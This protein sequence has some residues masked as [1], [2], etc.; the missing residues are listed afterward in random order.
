M[1]LR[2]RRGRQAGYAGKHSRP[3]RGW[4][5]LFACQARIVSFIESPCSS[6]P[7]LWHQV[8]SLLDCRSIARTGR[9]RHCEQQLTSQTGPCL[10]VRRRRSRSQDEIPSDRVQV[11]RVGGY[12]RIGRCGCYRAE[13]VEGGDGCGGQEQGIDDKEVG[14]TWWCGDSEVYLIGKWSGCGVW[15]TE[16]VERVGIAQ[17]Q[18]GEEVDWSTSEG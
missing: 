15:T 4:T 12:E 14:N 10:L 18:A 16:Y 17:T 11:D 8:L 5:S 7:A 3:A 9:H 6:S 13:E 2:R 1:C